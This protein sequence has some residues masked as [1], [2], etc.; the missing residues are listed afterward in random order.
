MIPV[1]GFHIEPTNIC[2]LKC[3]G[4]A[5]T[6]FINQWP[7]HWKN[8]NLE[9]SELMRFLD[10]DLNGITIN[11]CGD[12]GDPIYHP[13][14]IQMVSQIKDRGANV[15]I[16]TNGSYKKPE[17]WKELCSILTTTDQI[18]FSI[19]GLPDSFTQYRENADWKSIQ[20]GIITCVKSQIRTVWKFIP[21]EFNQTEIEQARALSQSLGMAEF[22]LDRS[23]RYDDQTAH[24]IPAQELVGARKSAQDQFRQQNT[25][26]IEPKCYV[27]REHFITATG[28]YAPCCYVADH[29]FYY[30][31]QF[32]KN[33]SGYDIR[34]YT[35]S[36]LMAQEKTQEF[37]QTIESSTPGVCQF[38]CPKVD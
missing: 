3:S 24:L 13:N 17:W 7:Q 18:R 23:D 5:R 14:F 38:N 20:S 22:L 1:E 21:F 36:E 37:Y 2:T 32:G 26:V 4:C 25:V 28:H 34:S 30:K 33:K 6:R 35:F 8:H 27:G 9:V 15:S 31:T 16:T 29:R 11:F 10:I 19:D 12:Y